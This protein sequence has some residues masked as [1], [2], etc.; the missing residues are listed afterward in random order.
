MTWI[1]YAILIHERLAV[2]WK[3]RKAAIMSILCFVV[4]SVSFIG[5]SLFI[6][7]YHNIKQI[8]RLGTIG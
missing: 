7:G 5:T 2:G 8:E 3:G 1:L 6:E 4:L